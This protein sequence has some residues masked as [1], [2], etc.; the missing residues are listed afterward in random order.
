MVPEDRKTEGLLLSLPV[1]IEPDSRPAGAAGP[2]R[3]A[4]STVDR[5]YAA[6]ATAGRPG[7]SFAASRYEQPVGQLSGGNQQ[8]VLMGR[9]LLREPEVSCSTS[10]RGASTSRPS[11][12]STT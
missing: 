5:E 4:G 3:W 10:R 7:R 2:V 11:S 12:R 9:W 6:A 8:K 1:R